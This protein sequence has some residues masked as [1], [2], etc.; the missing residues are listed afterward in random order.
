M[1]KY[2]ERK[3]MRKEEIWAKVDGKIATIS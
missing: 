1:R 3:N 2:I